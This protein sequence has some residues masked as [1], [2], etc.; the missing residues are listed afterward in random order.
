[1][2]EIVLNRY[3]ASSGDLL[4]LPK[5][6]L[7]AILDQ[8][9]PT[10][11]DRLRLHCDWA[12]PPEYIDWLFKEL[13]RLGSVPTLVAKSLHELGAV[14]KYL[15]NTTVVEIFLLKGQE[16]EEI[17]EEDITFH[18]SYFIAIDAISQDGS[19]Y[20][21][22]LSQIEDRPFSKTTLGV[23]WT[24]PVSGPLPMDEEDHGV[25][26]DT[27]ISVIESLSKK[28]I[29]SEF[30]CGLKLCIFSRE[31]LGHL[32]TRKVNWPIAVCSRNYF[33]DV[34]GTLS[35]CMLLQHS[36]EKKYTPSDNIMDVTED[37][38]E[39]LSPYLG[40]CLEAETL[41]CLCLKARSCQTGCLAHTIDEFKS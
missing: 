40:H 20:H 23:N 4:T 7:A 18:L 3:D 2:A 39:W 16:I 30:A 15:N 1:M 11:M 31:Q 34:D 37:F 21:G 14:K 5:E 24:S 38:L 19:L 10:S 27:V 32:P 33:Y 26:A 28:K 9:G 41:D 17:K 35:P 12:N 6:K 29:T 36:V 25:W 22:L 8:L 13:K